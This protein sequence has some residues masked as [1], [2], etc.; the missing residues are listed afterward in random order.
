MDVALAEIAVN[1]AVDAGDIGAGHAVTA[2]YEIEISC[3]GNTWSQLWSMS[4]LY[5]IQAM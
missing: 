4:I 2:L 3:H 1:D 5:I